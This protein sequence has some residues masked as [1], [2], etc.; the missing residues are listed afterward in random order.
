VHLTNKLTAYQSDEPTKLYGMGEQAV[1]LQEVIQQ[2]THVLSIDKGWLVALRC[3][4]CG[5]MV[6]ITHLCDVTAMHYVM[7]LLRH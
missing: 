5:L 1:K 7:M 4:V 2:V 3:A 6:V